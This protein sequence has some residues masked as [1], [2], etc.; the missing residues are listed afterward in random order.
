M[1]SQSFVF[2]GKVD[3][4][5]PYEKDIYKEYIDGP[6]ELLIRRSIDKLL[7][8]H[9]CNQEI[10]GPNRTAYAL[11]LTVLFIQVSHVTH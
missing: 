9:F 5:F 3:F 1:L 6:C 2:Q 7:A 8:E 10:P 11:L 4:H